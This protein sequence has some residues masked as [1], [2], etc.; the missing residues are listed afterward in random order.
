MYIPCNL[1]FM[2]KRP[3]AVARSWWISQKIYFITFKSY[4]SQQYFLVKTFFLNQSMTSQWPPKIVPIHTGHPVDFLLEANVGRHFNLVSSFVSIKVRSWLKNKLLAL[5]RKEYGIWNKDHAT[6][7]WQFFCFPIM[8]QSK[9]TFFLSRNGSIDLWCGV[10]T[11]IVF[12][13]FDELYYCNAMQ[14]TMHTVHKVRFLCTKDDS[15]WQVRL[16]TQSSSLVCGYGMLF[17]MNCYLLHG[18]MKSDICSVE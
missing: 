5:K 7:V 11:V 14:C 4:I 18:N 8:W 3:E 12:K 6:W 2:K 16:L 10:F 1:K 9:F 17:L 15:K 13:S